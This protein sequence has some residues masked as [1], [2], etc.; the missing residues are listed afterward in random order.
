MACFVVPVAEA[1]VATVAFKVLQSKAKKEEAIKFSNSENNFETEERTP[2]YKKLKWLTNLLWG[3]S[4]L[5]AFEHLWH[6]EVVPYFPFLSAAA[7]PQDTAQML[8][9][10]ATVGVMMAVAVTVVW[11]F[12]VAVSYAI[13]KQ[14][15]KAAKTAKEEV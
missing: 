14:S 10:M 8:H 15:L 7:N 6:G 13:E 3:G 12:M 1:V 4:F 2:F 11:L 9:E 5:L